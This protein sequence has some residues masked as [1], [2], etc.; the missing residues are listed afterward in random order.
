MEFTCA[1]NQSIR[2]CM[3]SEQSDFR[4]LSKGQKWKIISAIKIKIN[5]SSWIQYDDHTIKI[6]FFFFFFYFNFFEKFVQNCM[7][8]GCTMKYSINWKKGHAQAHSPWFWFL[9]AF[10][11]HS[12]FVSLNVLFEFQL[13]NQANRKTQKQQMM[14]AWI[15]KLPTFMLDIL[16]ICTGAIEGNHHKLKSKIKEFRK[17]E[18][19]KLG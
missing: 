4:V 11:V 10:F 14:Y 15:W 2:S 18:R 3:H 8:L 16:L 13:S 9:F 1:S 5:L 19:L 17:N 7:F 6:G 12:F